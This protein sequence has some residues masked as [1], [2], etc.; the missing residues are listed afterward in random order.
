[1]V[2]EYGVVT[3][4]YAYLGFLLV[5]LTF[6]FETGY[7]RFSS[8]PNASHKVYSTALFSL[9]A[10]NLTFLTAVILFSN[11]IISSLGY[12]N[13]PEYAVILAAII[14]LDSIAAIP[15][16]RLRQLNRPIVFS[17]I[18]FLIICPKVDYL[19]DAFFYFPNNAITYIFVANLIAS[20]FTTVIVIYLSRKEQFKFSFSDLKHLLIYSIPLLISG[21]GGTTNET[22]DR[23][24][25]KYL[26]PAEDNPMYQLGIYGSNVK[27]AV[28]M[29]LFI[30][31]YRYAAEPFFF[32]SAA[33][34]GSNTIYSITTKYFLAFTLLI[35]LGVGLFT[36]VF[37]YMVGKDFRTGLDVVPILL[38]ANVFYG[39]FFNL[40]IWYKLTNKTWYGIYFTF[41]GAAVTI[42]VNLLLTKH[43]GFYGAAWGR[44][45]CYVVMCV[46]C[47]VVGQ[48]FL[49]IP[50][51][52]KGILFNIVIALLIFYIGY[53]VEIQNTIL[54][55]LFRI[56]LIASYI[57]F[58]YLYEM[59][60]GDKQFNFKYR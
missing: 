8:L 23:I 4:M 22:F 11:S 29:V 10:V 59:R 20:I 34:K 12:P 51:D 30:Q 16:A 5:F 50:Y 47:F 40:S 43:I 35:F 28:L 6:G 60:F 48:R 49:K 46:V 9:V 57:L 44:L 21:I 37:K 33:H 56:V 39:L 19:K 24:F 27:L 26:V 36:D 52:I 58:F 18:F 55:F 17:T 31:M 54:S 45:L 3:E 32:K 7:F 25:I 13:K 2:E 15:F 53:T 42:T 14:S 1:L 41:I 38:L